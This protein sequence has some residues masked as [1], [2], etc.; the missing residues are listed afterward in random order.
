MS[1]NYTT[2]GRPFSQRH[3]ACDGCG[4]NCDCDCGMTGDLIVNGGMER[5]RKNIPLGWCSS[6]PDLVSQVTS[7][8]LVH[9]GNCSA[10]ITQGGSLYQI[11][12]GID[13]GFVYRLCFFAHGNGSPVGLT[14][15]ITF[16]TPCGD[17]LGGKITVRQ[18]DL[19]INAREFGYYQLV[20]CAAPVDTTK[21]TVQFTANACS[22]QSL[23]LD[24]VSL[25][26]I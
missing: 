12:H 23:D 1:G 9:S 26:I 7:S 14:A 11:V 22:F 19:P 6:T 21:A 2:N 15:K 17:S 10:G 20:T 16:H 13:P 18:A 25:T 4:C 3:V 5:F 8:G 24:D